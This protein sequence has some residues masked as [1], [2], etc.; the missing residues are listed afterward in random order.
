MLEKEFND[1]YDSLYKL[2]EG[3]CEEVGF[4]CSQCPFYTAFNE[5]GC[6]V[7]KAKY[8]IYKAENR[9]RLR[10]RNKIKRDKR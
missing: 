7:I 5:Y 8:E 1:V 6:I 4:K 2:A 3:M 10:E 9:V